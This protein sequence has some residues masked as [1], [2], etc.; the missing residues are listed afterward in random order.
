MAGRGLRVRAPVSYNDKDSQMVPAWLRTIQPSATDEPTEKR[1]KPASKNKKISKR[2][3]NNKENADGE[4]ASLVAA[5]VVDTVKESTSKNEDESKTKKKSSIK[6]TKGKKVVAA[7][8]RNAGLTVVPIGALLTNSVGNWREGVA[9]L[10]EGMY[11][12]YL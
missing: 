4:A 6:V 8:G 10:P 12:Q 2:T 11:T 1:K 9:Q 3:V 5:G 7:R